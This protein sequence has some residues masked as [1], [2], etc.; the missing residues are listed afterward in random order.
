MKRHSLCGCRLYRATNARLG[1]TSSV[2]GRLN[3]GWEAASGM[4]R[5]YVMGLNNNR[6]R[7][8]VK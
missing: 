3:G 7:A 6:G 8:D 5:V 1:R 2:T 4:Q